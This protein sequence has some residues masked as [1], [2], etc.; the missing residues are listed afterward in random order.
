MPRP[1]LAVLLGVVDRNQEAAVRGDGRKGE[2]VGEGQSPSRFHRPPRRRVAA[3]RRE[4]LH[5]DGAAAAGGLH[6]RRDR[7]VVQAHAAAA[8]RQVLCARSGAV[9]D[10][11]RQVAGALALA[12]PRGALAGADAVMR[13]LG[14]RRQI[15]AAIRVVPQPRHHRCEAVCDRRRRD[16]RNRAIWHSSGTAPVFLPQRS[17]LQRGLLLAFCGSKLP[18]DPLAATRSAAALAAALTPGTH[19]WRVANPNVVEVN[20]AFSCGG[21]YPNVL[22]VNGAASCGGDEGPQGV[23]QS[24]FRS[25]KVGDPALDFKRRDLG[26]AGLQ[27]LAPES[28]RLQ[29]RLRQGCRPLAHA[30]RIRVHCVELGL[31]R[32]GLGAERVDLFALLGELSFS[33]SSGAYVDRTRIGCRFFSRA[34]LL[35]PRLW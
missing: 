4:A 13:V 3:D 23:R 25:G 2:F 14:G 18:C 11:P 26:H 32:V 17:L 24:V 30:S 21:P 10:H 34:H 9:K 29:W 31:D 16:E 5:A 6:L 15:R 12:G 27:L 28:E 20:G 19:P 1:R 22:E 7:E 8:V 33:V 35:E